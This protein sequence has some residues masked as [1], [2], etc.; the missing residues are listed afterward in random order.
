[1]TG[2]PKYFLLILLFFHQKTTGI[3]CFSH[4]PRFIVFLQVLPIAL[5]TGPYSP[6]HDT[7]PRPLRMTGNGD[8]D[9]IV[10]R[11]ASTVLKTVES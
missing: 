10:W 2:F 8:D 4:C 5:Y 7:V 3:N 11:H 9:V 6:K 1:V